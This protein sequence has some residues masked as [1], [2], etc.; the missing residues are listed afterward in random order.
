MQSEHILLSFLLPAP[1]YLLPLI[2]MVLCA[3]RWLSVGKWGLDCVGVTW[4][5]V[6]ID[7]SKSWEK[8]G[9]WNIA[10]YYWLVQNYKNC[11][12]ISL[13]S[14]VRYI[15]QIY[16]VALGTKPRD[17]WAQTPQTQ[18]TDI[19]GRPERSLWRGWKS[20]ETCPLTHWP[21]KEV[22]MLSPSLWVVPIAW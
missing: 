10:G 9:R 12:D 21:V 18:G 15:S 5:G 22:I 8:Y 3:L 7:N 17:S 16:L 13:L 14:N 6:S 2:F 19:L 4:R 11:S 20:L 1:I